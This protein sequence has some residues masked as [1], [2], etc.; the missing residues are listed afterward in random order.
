[1]IAVGL[2]KIEMQSWYVGKLCFVSTICILCYAVFMRMGVNWYNL[3]L[4]L[5]R[6]ELWT[7]LWIVQT[8]FK[9]LTGRWPG[10]TGRGIN[11]VASWQNCTWSALVVFRVPMN[12]MRLYG[13]L[14]VIL[15]FRRV[16]KCPLQALLPSRTDVDSSAHCDP[17]VYAA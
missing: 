13:V 15:Y 5:I 12:S 16:L 8:H 4:N 3:E 6:S 10:M 14:F 11:G 2:Y 1:M 17:T 9:F 7:E